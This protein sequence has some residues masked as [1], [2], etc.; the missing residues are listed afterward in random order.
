MP[1]VADTSPT[2]LT[3]QLVTEDL[4]AI[5]LDVAVKT[6]QRWRWLRKGP[7]WLKIE[8]AVRYDL[9]DIK[10][11]KAACRQQPVEAA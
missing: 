8:G 4:A 9:A 7:A 1:T 6:L 10:A 3:G 5:E 11:Y 2:P